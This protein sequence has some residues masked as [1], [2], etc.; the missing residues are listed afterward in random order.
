MLKQKFKK[1]VTV[2]IL[3]PQL[4]SLSIYCN[5]HCGLF[6]QWFPVWIKL[7]ESAFYLII[8]L[9][10]PPQWFTQPPSF[11]P[12]AWLLSGLMEDSNMR[13]SCN[14][15]LHSPT[16][17]PPISAAAR[18]SPWPPGSDYPP[19]CVRSAVSVIRVPSCPQ[20]PVCG[21]DSQLEH[22][23]LEDVLFCVCDVDVSIRLV[24]TWTRRP[25]AETQ[26]FTSSFAQYLVGFL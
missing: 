5:Q 13:C 11:A 4:N 23:C 22:S 2:V 9:L 10:I 1:C 12:F 21:A 16:R 18:H 7:F 19:T 20:M 26:R 14:D 17:S 3:C 25:K 24:Q 6:S 8:F 15:T